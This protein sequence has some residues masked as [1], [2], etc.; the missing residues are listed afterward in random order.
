YRFF[1]SEN[2]DAT[3]DLL[4]P[5][6]EQLRKSDFDVGGAV[7]TVLCSNLFFSP[8]AYR[9]RVKAPVD[10]ALGIVHALEGRIGTTGLAIALD[11]LGQHVF[12]PPSVKGWDGGQA[13]L[14]GHTLLAR[15]NLALA[16][17]STE[18][19]L[20]GRHTDPAVLVRKHDLKS[21]TEIVD[22][23]LRLFLQGDAPAESRQ[24]IVDYAARTRKSQ[25]PAYWTDEDAAA[26]RVRSV[27]HLVLALPEFQL[28]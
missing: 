28:D 24:K 12:F 6:A 4:A 23:F 9:S 3:P 15:Q 21:N 18:N 10:F 19:L 8:Q 2:I 25:V 27:C 26:H 5:L 11:G 7:R 16:L 13:W 17:T 14:N 22:F 20:F 1:V